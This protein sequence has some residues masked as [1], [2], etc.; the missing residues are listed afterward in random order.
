MNG[1]EQRLALARALIFDC[2][3]TL[4][5]SGPVYCEAWAT[6]LRL[7]GI[8]MSRE[9]YH[10]RVGLSE[11][12]LLDSF[13]RDHGVDLDRNAVVALMRSTYLGSLHQLRVNSAVAAIARA[14]DGRVPLAVASGGPRAIV[15]PSLQ[16]CGLA[17][18]FD[19][20]VTL[21]DGGRAKPEPDLFLMAARRLAVPPAQCLVFEDSDQG[22]QAAAS[23]GMPVVDVRGILEYR[24]HPR[25]F[26]GR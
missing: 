13:E 2:D 24:P 15:V 18:L 7:S 16:A 23:A 19:A 25:E 20:I 4:V 11:H 17:G 5:D 12:V 21:D 6:G 10:E 8:E 26:N 14:N 9:W 22:L 3:G 1:L